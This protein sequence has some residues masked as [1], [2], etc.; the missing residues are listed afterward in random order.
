METLFLIL[1]PMF[2]VSAVIAVVY[3]SV[4]AVWKMLPYMGVVAVVLGAALFAVVAAI[5]GA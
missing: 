5:Q 3:W 1:F 2:V 4:V